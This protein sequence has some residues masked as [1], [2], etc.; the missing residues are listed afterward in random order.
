MAGFLEQHSSQFAAELW[1]FLHSGLSI[2]AFD[3]QVF[4]AAPA[5]AG[6][7][8]AAPSPAEGGAGAEPPYGGVLHADDVEQQDW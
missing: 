2:A 1:S 7:L 5:A 8:E 3:K 6:E 4:G